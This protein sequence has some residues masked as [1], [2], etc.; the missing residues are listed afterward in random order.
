[1]DL[2]V[3]A[4]VLRRHKVIVVGGV[5][6]AVVLA[7]LS[8]AKPTL[9]NGKPG[10]EPRKQEVWQSS[11]TLFLTQRGFP[12]GRT[13]Q[14]LVTRKIGNSEQTVAQYADPGRFTSL[15]PLY[16][17]LANSDAVKRLVLRTGGP[18]VGRVKALP[19]A[20]TSYGLVNG[21]PMITI[22]G[23]A[24]TQKDA[25]VGATRYANGFTQFLV[26]SQKQAKIPK[27]KR[28]VVEVLNAAG[29]DDTL[30]VPRK[31]TLPI[32]VFL[33]IM[34][35][36]IALAFVRE[37]ALRGAGQPDTAAPPAPAPTPAPAVDLPRTAE[38]R[39]A[40]SERWRSSGSRATS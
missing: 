10:L 16:A 18:I 11:V 35:A 29:S 34:C 40:Q 27:D 24:S 22:F 26:A 4:G 3:L 28:V 31:K 5:L 1:M 32:V 13:E 33:A 23:T 25:R 19:T 9:D 15:A 36:T 30:L 8:Y 21:L 7:T 20:D 17:K 6:V 2:R 38:G 12:A 14:P 39:P 37:N